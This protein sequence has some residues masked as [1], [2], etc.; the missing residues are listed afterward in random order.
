MFAIYFYD[1]HVGP[2]IEHLIV[3]FKLHGELVKRS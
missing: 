3:L 1:L 2:I